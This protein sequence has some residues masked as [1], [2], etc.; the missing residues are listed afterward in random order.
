V[1]DMVRGA[2]TESRLK[3]LELLDKNRREKALKERPMVVQDETIGELET[4]F[5]CMLAFAGDQK[6]DM[7]LVDWIKDNEG[8]GNHVWLLGIEALIT[9]ANAGM[10]AD[11]ANKIYQPL[12]GWALP[13]KWEKRKYIAGYL[14]KPDLSGNS[15]LSQAEVCTGYMGLTAAKYVGMAGKQTAIV[16]PNPAKGDKAKFGSDPEF[17]NP[18][19]KPKPGPVRH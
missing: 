2:S 19:P 8:K 17:W 5:T 4:L 10:S 15:L 9:E 7:A 16:V 18:P 12:L 3:A 6:E 13:L 1:P 14:P 11:R